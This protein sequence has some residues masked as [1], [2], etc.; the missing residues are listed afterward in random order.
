M[1][2]QAVCVVPNLDLLNDVIILQSWNIH[3]FIPSVIEPDMIM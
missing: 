2:L 3:Q 1:E